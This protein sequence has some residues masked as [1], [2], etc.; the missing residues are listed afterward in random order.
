MARADEKAAPAATSE[1]A[2]KLAELEAENARLKGDLAAAQALLSER[3]VVLAAPKTGVYAKCRI[4][5]NSVVFEPDAPLTF[6]PDPDLVE[7][8]HW[9]RAHAS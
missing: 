5:H 7:G 9:Y 3:A 8:V 4:L 1:L 6:T 2:A